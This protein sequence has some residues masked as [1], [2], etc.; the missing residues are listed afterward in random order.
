MATVEAMASPVFSP[1]PK[2][3]E[4]NIP[5]LVE[6]RDR[7][8]GITRAPGTVKG[9]AHDWSMFARWCREAGRDALPA[10]SDTLA[11]YATWMLAVNGRKVT[12]TS[13]HVSA[14]LHHHRVAGCPV[15]INPWNIICAVRRERHERPQGRRALTPD[16]ILSISR[17]CAEDT[18]AGRRDRAIVLLGFASSLRR[19]SL[20][21]L[22]LADLSFA[23]RG[24][25]ISVHDE[26]NDR[27]GHGRLLGVWPGRKPITDPI[28]ALKDW[29][30]R[31]GRLPGC[32]FTR[33]STSDRIQSHGLTGEAI[34]DAIKR[35][36][37]RAGIDSRPYGSHS[38]RAGAITAAA[39]G[40]ATDH[41][42]MSLSGHRTAAVMRGYIRPARMFAGRNPLSGAL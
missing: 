15:P 4:V 12:T 30:D 35:S 14:I 19:S 6:M 32:L 17:A 37:D 26:K 24:L 33:I 13:R 5:G 27:F 1:A 29:L 21:R 25:I 20:A 31:R 40:G 8:A 18:N 16:E 39:V 42:I 38:L 23:D 9:Y 11:L 22:E 36:I 10:S 2:P 3:R 34:H 7:L 41:E 28:L